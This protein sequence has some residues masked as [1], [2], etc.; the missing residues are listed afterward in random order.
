[1]TQVSNQDIARI[2]KVIADYHAMEG[3]AFKPQAY[4]RAAQTV[5]DLDKDL[6]DIYNAGGIKALKAIPG[7]GQ[8]IAEHIERTFENG[9]N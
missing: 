7:I 3:V 2:L 4:M 8:S 1:M 5:A 6:R 9:K